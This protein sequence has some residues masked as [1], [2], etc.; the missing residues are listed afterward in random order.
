MLCSRT[1]LLA[2]LCLRTEARKLSRRDR[3][4]TIVDACGFSLVTMSVGT[5]VL[6]PARA[7]ERAL[8][9]VLGAKVAAL[10][11]FSGV[12]AAES[13]GDGRYDGPYL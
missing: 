7:L 6:D 9:I 3:Y 2:L 4:A 12:E 8:V 13:G 11:I 5:S 10:A 1:E